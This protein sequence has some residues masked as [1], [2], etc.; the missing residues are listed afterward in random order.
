MNKRGRQ[1]P[2]RLKSKSRPRKAASAASEPPLAKI[3]YETMFKHLPVAVYRT[4]PGGKILTANPA[5]AKTLGF[6][7]TASLRN[8]DVRSL[9]LDKQDRE[10]HFRAMAKEGST[11]SEFRLKRKDG[12][13]IW[14]RDLSRAIVGPKGRILYTDGVMRDISREKRVESRLRGALK[15][16]AKA[17]A[18]RDE[19]IRKLER[20]SLKDD[21]TGLCNRRGFN[22]LARQHILVADRQKNPTYL[23][24]LDL[25]DLKRINDTFGHRIGDE[26]LVNLA[27]ILNSTFRLSDIKARMGGDEFAVFPIDTNQAGVNA[28]VGRLEK[29]IFDF[30]AAGKTPYTLGFSI[31]VA[32]YDPA[33]PSSVEDLLGRADNLMYEEKRRKRAARGG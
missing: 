7:S 17:K 3:R 28:A 13:V 11:I 8:V 5:L 22:V 18:D 24:Y 6:K 31:G 27:G 21:L 10:K 16:L 29:A 12:R 19:M 15:R 25:D 26:A 4:T 9:F 1:G 14:V 33:S 20:I 23:L 2:S 32:C 30:N